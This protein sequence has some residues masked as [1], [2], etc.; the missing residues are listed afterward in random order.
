M[1]LSL[2]KYTQYHNHYNHLLLSTKQVVNPGWLP[3]D[4]SRGARLAGRM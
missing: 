4:T 2:Q 3:S 1:R